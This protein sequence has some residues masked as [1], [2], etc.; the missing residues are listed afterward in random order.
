VRLDSASTPVA[1]RRNGEWVNVAELLDRYRTVD[2][3]WAEQPVA[4]TYYEV[5]LEDGRI[6]T[7]FHDEIGDCWHE[8]RYG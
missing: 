7:I 3:W 2:R 5:L 1:L 4:R 8:Q 6:V